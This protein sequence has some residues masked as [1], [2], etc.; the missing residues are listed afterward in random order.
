V[1]V[2]GQQRGNAIEFAEAYEISEYA[3]DLDDAA[4]KRLFPCIS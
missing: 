1:E 2:F 3:S 4:R